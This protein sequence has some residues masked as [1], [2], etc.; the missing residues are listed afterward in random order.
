MSKAPAVGSLHL[1]RGGGNCDNRKAY[2]SYVLPTQRG[3]R[4]FECGAISKIA[5]EKD[6]RELFIWTMI[7]GRTAAA[8]WGT[9]A[10]LVVFELSL[11]WKWRKT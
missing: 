9:C 6:K 1:L 2:R 10:C 11:L 7:G 5:V 4:R 3:G 8:T